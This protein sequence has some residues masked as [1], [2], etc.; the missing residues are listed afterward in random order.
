M[1][2][3]VV[4][5]GAVTSPTPPRRRRLSVDDRRAELLGAC[6]DLIGTR[7][8]DEISMADIAAAAGVSKPL[9]YHY[10]STKPELYLSTVESAADEL[11]HA[12]LLDPELAPEQQRQASLDAYLDWIEEHSTAYRAVLQ[13]GISS[14][15]RVQAVVDR[16]R[17]V[18]VERIAE[19]LGWR[20]VSAT[21]RVSLRGWVGFLEAA[22]LEW[23]TTRSI[24]RAELV[25][26]LTRT[27]SAMVAGSRRSDDS[28]SAPHR[29]DGAWP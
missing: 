23:L 11:R 24:S 17:A 8:W 16:S 29:S 1:P 9:L 20:E 14:D 21:Q 22:C 7:P 12:T 27:A 3:R 13:G 5:T 15:A 28:R 4:G 19:T 25:D 6:L 18:V 10:F 26:I 2:V